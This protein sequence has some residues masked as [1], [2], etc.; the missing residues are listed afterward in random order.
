MRAPSWGGRIGGWRAEVGRSD[1]SGG[2]GSVLSFTDL[3]TGKKLPAMGSLSG[4]SQ[5]GSYFME[6]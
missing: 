2:E 4:D 1:E 5:R 3:L 6:F